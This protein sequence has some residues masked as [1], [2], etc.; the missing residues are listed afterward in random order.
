MIDPITNINDRLSFIKQLSFSV[1]QSNENKAKLALLIISINRMHRI[2]EIYDFKTGDAALNYLVEKLNEAKR[3]QDSIGRLSSS[4]FGLILSPIMNKGH[5]QLAAHKILR[6]LEAPLEYENHRVKLDISI[7]IS[8]CPSHSS[9]ATGLLK[10]A[11][12][13]LRLA[14]I[15]EA[16]L[17]ITEDFAQDE[18]T[19]FWDIEL[20]IEQAILKSEF[21]LYYQ[22]KI[23][24]KTGLPSGSEAL[25]RWP[26]PN[27]GMIY[28]DQFIPVAE[29]HGYI[30][31]M[32][33]WILNVALRES[34][35]WTT[36]FGPLSLSVNIPPDL[37]NVELVDLVD[38]ALNI[39]QPEN[40]T[41]VLEILERSFALTNDDTF[42]TFEALQNLGTDISIDDFGTG[43]S[44]L[45]YFKSIPAR[46]LKI[47]KSFIQ[48]LLDE[49]GNFDIVTFIIKLAHAFNMR[50]VAEG[51]EDIKTMKILKALGCDYMQGYIASK[52]MPHN[53]FI[54]YLEHYTI[55]KQAFSE[56]YTSNQD[57]AT[58]IEKNIIQIN[59]KEDLEDLIDIIENSSEANNQHVEEK[60]KSAR[61]EVLK[62]I[63]PTDNTDK[64]NKKRSL[65]EIEIINT[66]LIKEPL[67]NQ[68]EKIQDS[69]VRKEQ[70]DLIGDIDF[71]DTLI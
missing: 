1:Q 4:S 19:E 17:S 46:E 36:K 34:A 10:K 64:M 47:D 50:I 7:G 70:S 45:S 66:P 2:N 23:N 14:R 16:Q 56:L 60:V 21:Q 25:I 26:H 32:T 49:Q 8:I 39:W 27:R 31:P 63:D 40:I 69:E 51:V 53:E 55:E 48:N 62:Q 41:L 71:G 28:P 22:P 9:L 67:S 15:Q 29:D 58:I 61:K 3:T 59:S 12:A 18:I 42:S 30:K 57:I 37:M 54:D 20:G 6:L 52:P 38:N 11:E 13:A 43:Y 5:A 68:S 44:A 24:L 65:A 35:Q 33:I